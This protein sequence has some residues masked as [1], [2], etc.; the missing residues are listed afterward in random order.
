MLVDV[1]EIFAAVSCCVHAPAHPEWERPLRLGAGRE[2]GDL[3]GSGM[4]Q[5]ELEKGPRHTLLHGRYISQGDLQ[6]APVVLIGAFND[7]WNL[8]VT[9]PLRFNFAGG[10]SIRDNYDKKR[11]WA[12]HVRPD[13]TT[14]DDDAI[15][16]RLL[17][18][19]GGESIMT[20]A[21]I[22]HYGTEAAPDFLSS[23]E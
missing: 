23:P 10:S 8:R 3:V 4:Q 22:G 16:T 12:V 1:V 2:P 7:S 11:S 5:I 17:G 14:T 18:P 15:I 19:D 20:A 21:G 9:N 6:S 13:G